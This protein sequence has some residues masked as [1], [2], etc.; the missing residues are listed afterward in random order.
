MRY[1]FGGVCAAALV[2]LMVVDYYLVKSCGDAEGR[3]SYYLE[4][5]LSPVLAAGAV[6]ACAFGRPSCGCSF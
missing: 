2:A 6:A 3:D 4:I 1:A 5:S